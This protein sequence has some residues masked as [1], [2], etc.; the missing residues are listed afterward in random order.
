MCARATTS[1][2][3]ISEFPALKAF[4]HSSNVQMLLAFSR[5]HQLGCKFVV[6]GRKDPSTGKFLRMADVP[7]PDEI[8]DWGLFAGLTEPQFRKDISSTELRKRIAQQQAAA[9]TAAAEAK[10]PNG[11]AAKTG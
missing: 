11:V 3:V 9:S 5:L 8:A 10:S 4:T 6:A 1:F 7:V 2:P